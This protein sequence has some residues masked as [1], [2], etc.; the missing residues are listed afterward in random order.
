MTGIDTNN[1]L[2]PTILDEGKKRPSAILVNMYGG[3]MECGVNA[4]NLVNTAKHVLNMQVVVPLEDTNKIIPLLQES[5]KKNTSYSEVLNNVV[6]TL[7]R[8]VKNSKQL[9]VECGKTNRVYIFVSY[10]SIAKH[11]EKIN[12]KI[13]HAL[14]LIPF[15]SLDVSSNIVEDMTV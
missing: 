11:K 6:E 13:S 12:R 14:N 3:I 4:S 9:I 1:T 15:A 5:N 2:Y 8:E 10:G 7:N